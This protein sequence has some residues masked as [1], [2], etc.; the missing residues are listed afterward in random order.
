MILGVKWSETDSVRVMPG[1]VGGQKTQMNQNLE[2]ILTRSANKPSH[3]TLGGM[4]GRT[5]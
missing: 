5:N 3:Q 2:D 1:L 4:E